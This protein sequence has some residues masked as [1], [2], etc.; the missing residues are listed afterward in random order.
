[1]IPNLDIQGDGGHGRKFWDQ[2]A[3]GDFCDGCGALSAMPA[4]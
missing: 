1:M 2:K 3:G 4:R